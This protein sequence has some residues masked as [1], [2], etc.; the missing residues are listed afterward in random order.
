AAVGEADGVPGV[1]PPLV[2]QALRC[3]PLVLDVPVAVAIAVP[4][5]PVQG[6]IGMGQ[7]AVDELL[8]EAPA[9]HLPEQH[10][11]ERGGVDGAVVDAASAQ[12]QPGDATEADLV[13]DPSG[14]LLGGRVDRLT[15]Q[16]GAGLPPAG[17]GASSPHRNRSAISMPFTE[18]A[19]SMQ[20]SHVLRGSSVV[21]H[22]TSPGSRWEW[23]VGAT[24]TS[25][26]NPRSVWV[27]VSTPRSRPW[28]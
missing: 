6:P 22:A 10:H 14:L 19:T 1:L 20:S 3:G 4:L 12:R 17:L 9:P 5:D 23:P 24:T 21:R 26:S 28:G 27:N 8:M 13:Q 16:T 11:E 25:R 2:G 7:Q 15:L 18:V